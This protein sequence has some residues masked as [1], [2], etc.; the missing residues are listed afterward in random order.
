MPFGL[1]N[2]QAT[3]SR[4]VLIAFKE[5]IHNFL[6]VL[7]D[8]WK[9][10]GL[11]KKHIENLRLMLNMCR[12]CKIYV[13][14]KKFIFCAPFGILLGQ[15]VCNQGLLVD[16]A[17]I[18]VIVNL[19]PPTSMRQLRKTLGHTRYYRKIIKGYAQV[20]TL[21]EKLLKKEILSFSGM[22]NASRF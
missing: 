18:V 8:D 16:L 20:T 6:E 2:A 10:F 9:V 1:K 19:P 22:R 4:V 11:L 5:F 17:K 7:F 21:V 14:L 3:F 12:Q 15:V 13:N